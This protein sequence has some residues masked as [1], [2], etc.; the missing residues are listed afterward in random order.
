MAPR[1]AMA[2]HSITQGDT[3]RLDFLIA[4]QESLLNAYRCLYKIDTHIVPGGCFERSELNPS[5]TR[6][7]AVATGYR[8]S[9]ALRTDQT[10]TCWG[11][12]SSGQANPPN[13]THTAIATGST[14]SCALRTDQTITCWD[15]TKSLPDGVFLVL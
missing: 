10:I 4:E 2:Q 14:H 15:W 3:V 11:N 7:V 1:T 13:G 8:H 12:N 5:M 9:C 6:F